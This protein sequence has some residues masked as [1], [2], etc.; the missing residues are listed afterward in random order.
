MRVEQLQIGPQQVRCARLSSAFELAGQSYPVGSWLVQS[1]HMTYAE[2]MRDDQYQ[3][4][5]ADHLAAGATVTTI[6]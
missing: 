3:R 2:P 1:R 6:E 5:R 4:W